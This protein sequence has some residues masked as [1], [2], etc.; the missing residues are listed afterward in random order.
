MNNAGEGAGEGCGENILEFPA[1][2]DHGSNEARR[3]LPEGEVMTD[4]LNSLS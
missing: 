2:R 4:H 3:A 1:E